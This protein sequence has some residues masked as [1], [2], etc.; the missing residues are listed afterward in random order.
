M[1]PA[2]HRTDPQAEFLTDE[3][4]YI[5]E[6]INTP[7][8]PTL[9]IA[10]ARVLPGESTALH[11]LDGVTER[12]HLLAGRGTVRLGSGD[13]AK[14]NAGDSVTIPAGIAQQIHNTGDDDLVFL[15]ICTPRFVPECY[16]ALEAAEDPRAG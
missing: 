3:G 14:V 13:E 2:I 1:K 16:V 6:S 10:R 4:C 9:S 11:R 8:D 15:C 5:L 7:E 12:Y